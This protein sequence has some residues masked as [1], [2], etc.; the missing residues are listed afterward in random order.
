M[1]PAGV[2]AFPAWTGGWFGVLNKQMED[3]TEF[4]KRG[5]L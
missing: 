3:F 1:T 4:E 5:Y 2:Q